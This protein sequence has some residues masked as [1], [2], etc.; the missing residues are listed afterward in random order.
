M[1]RALLQDEAKA[2][3]GHLGDKWPWRGAGSGPALT[4]GHGSSGYFTAEG[5]SYWVEGG[6]KRRGPPGSLS[7]SMTLRSF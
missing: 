1:W 6:K 3:G 7:D 5:T 4:R 2:N